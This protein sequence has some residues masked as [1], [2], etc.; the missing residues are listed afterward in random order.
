MIICER[1]GGEVLGSSRAQSINPC[2]C[3]QGQHIFI[4]KIGDSYMRPERAANEEINKNLDEILSILRRDSATEALKRIASIIDF[5]I[6]PIPP[7]EGSFYILNDDE[8][9]LI[10]LCRDVADEELKKRGEKFL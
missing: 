2:R 6:A 8:F 5:N 10:M 9:L 3:V 1:C 7:S 4:S